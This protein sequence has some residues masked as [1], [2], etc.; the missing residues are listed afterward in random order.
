MLDMVKK[1]FITAAFPYPNS[2]QHIGHARTYT[3]TDIHARF[4]KLQGYN[5]LFPMAFHVTGT[6]I[7]AMAERIKENDK[8]LI[9]IFTNI[10]NIPKSEISKLSDPKSLVLYFSQE[11]EKGMK[12]MNFLIDWS[13]KFY[14]FDSHFNKFIQWQFK[15]LKDKGLLVKGEHPVPWSIKL[16]SAVGAHDTKGDVD[17]ELEEIT[18]IK[19]KFNDGFL[20]VST[21]RPETI[22]GVTNIWINPNS[23]IAK[24]KKDDE[25]IYI[26]KEAY[27]ILKHQWNLELI[28]TFEGKKIINKS[29]RNLVTNEEIPIYPAYFVK[30]DVGTGVV[31]SVP[32]HAPYDYVAMRDLGILNVKK[33]INLEG[34]NIPAEDIVKKYNIKNQ[35]DPKLEDATKELYKLEFKKG[36]FLPLNKPVK[37]A[38]EI[39]RENMISSNNAYPLWV[40][41]NEVFSRAGDKVIVKK[42]KN[43]WFIDYGNKEWKEKT[44]EWINKMKIIP[45]SMKE[46]LLKT[47]DWLDKKA[48]T[49]SRGLGTRFPF[50]K[51]L[52]IESL[53]DS[54]IYP[55]FY[56]ISNKIKSFSPEQLDEAFFDYIFLGKGKPI[57]ELHKELRASFLYYYPVDARHSGADL[58]RNHLVFYIMNHIAIFPKEFWPKSII[59][60][61]FVLMEGKKMSKSMGNILPLRSAIKTYGSDVIRFSVVS[62]AELLQDTDF[63]KGS[64]EGIKTRLKFF[65]QLI[66]KE[67]SKD[68]KPIDEWIKAIFY[69]DLENLEQ[70]FET[71][72]FR[73]ITLTYFYDF[74]K[75]IT[76]YL[77]RRGK[78]QV[79][80]SILYDW[81]NIMYPFMPN[82]VS[83]FGRE[84]TSLPKPKPF[85]KSILLKEEL[86]KNIDDDIDRI[87]RLLKKPIKKIEITYPH[88]WKYSF[89]NELKN[90]NDFKS[91][92]TIAKQGEHVNEKMK[93]VKKFKNKLFSLQS[94]VEREEAINYVR[95]NLDFLKQKYNVEVELVSEDKKEAYPFKFGVVLHA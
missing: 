81:L 2:P 7:L 76:W 95:E 75:H 41:T 10:Y 52:M 55:A 27:E 86:I 35:N 15:K 44:R 69:K 68:N 59:V 17:P 4:R 31:M 34:F 77:E 78:G 54:T 88:E 28:E 51:T 63:N 9:D 67:D 89:F 43:Q 79:L 66:R 8:E 40:I 64:A 80:K 82:F 72:E 56:T 13:R 45:E 29:A 39:I 83:S 12:E 3:I 14:T 42:V 36:I 53:S 1:F 94:Y 30:P 47:V 46:Q 33:I 92:I 19:F 32:A 71:F 57:N 84:F 74:H 16:N 91:L 25:I 50:D 26:T 5:V 58:I 61:G 20:V 23:T 73:K 87:A 11:V 49:R 18:A 6:P 60:N 70:L 37:E 21:Y 22:Y 85:D 90:I 24:I 93:I 48:C 62:G 65:E 38:K